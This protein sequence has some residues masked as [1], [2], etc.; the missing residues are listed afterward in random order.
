MSSYNRIIIGTTA[1]VYAGR[2]RRINVAILL[3]YTILAPKL[4]TKKNIDFENNIF[5]SV[6]PR[7]DGERDDDVTRNYTSVS[8]F[9]LYFYDINYIY[10]SRPMSGQ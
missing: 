10:I 3:Y 1:F 7:V 9:L 4:K 6:Y 5:G 8:V 2:N